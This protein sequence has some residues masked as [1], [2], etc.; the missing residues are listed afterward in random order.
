MNLNLNFHFRGTVVAQNFET[1][2]DEIIYFVDYSLKVVGYSLN[3][4][5]Y[6]FI[7]R[8]S[9]DRTHPKVDNEK[10]WIG[11]MTTIIADEV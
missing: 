8:Q 3:I 11:D 9:S 2:V 1:I 5:G 10:A 7:D 6:S 4:V